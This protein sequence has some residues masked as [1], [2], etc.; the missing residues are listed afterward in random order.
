VNADHLL[1]LL[2]PVILRVTLRRVLWVSALGAIALVVASGTLERVL[3]ACTLGLSVFSM[4]LLWPLRL[5][6]RLSPLTDE[7]T[8]QLIQTASVS[9]S[10]A[11]LYRVIVD[12]CFVALA[13]WAALWLAP[14]AG[15][16]IGLIL[17][18][19]IAICRWVT[20]SVSAQ[21]LDVLD[22]LVRDLVFARPGLVTRVV[23]ADA[24]S[25]Q[26]KGV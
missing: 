24:A 15:A 7:D 17:G 13:A 18:M 21:H 22:P 19:Q 9:T 2:V 12:G 8:D 4:V 23:E 16:I 26:A 20:S 3:T 10:T 6:Q 1:G 5:R 25:R 14:L 11:R